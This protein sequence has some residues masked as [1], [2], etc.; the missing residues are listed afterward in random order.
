MKLRRT[1]EFHLTCK[2]DETLQNIN[3]GVTERW[4]SPEAYPRCL[5]TSHWHSEP[6]CPQS[7]LSDLM[8]RSYKKA[9]NPRFLVI[10]KVE[11]ICTTSENQKFD[12]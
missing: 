9:R 6:M 11:K 5:L 12:K 3:I 10:C 4:Y 1:V 2:L 7:A 8:F